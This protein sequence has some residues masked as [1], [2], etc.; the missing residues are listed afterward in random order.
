MPAQLKNILTV[1]DLATPEEI[2]AG[3]SW[4]DDAHQFAQ[5]LSIDADLPLEKVCGVISA[6][7]PATDW[8]RNKMDARNLIL[9]APEG[10][11]FCTYGLNVKKAQAILAHPDNDV[12]GYFSNAY[13]TF[14][15]YHNILNP[16]NPE[17]V[18]I[19]RHAL[20]VA[21]GKTREDK[22]IN[23]GEYKLL[24][25]LYN[26]AAKKTKLLP[27]QIQAI[28]WVV[29]RNRK[30]LKSKFKIKDIGTE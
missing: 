1:L 14:N 2:A 13:K 5:T 24:A 7:S 23:K 4:Y 25:T 27:A 20:S 6:L 11:K 30:G 29:W 21:L 15:F 28:T 9:G 19:D 8:E 16:N 10:Y 22:T 12:Q 3:K 17:Y 18:T 26:K